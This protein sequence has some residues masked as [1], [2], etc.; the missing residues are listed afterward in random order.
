MMSFFQPEELHPFH[1]AFRGVMKFMNLENH[2]TLIS[3]ENLKLN[4][5]P[6]SLSHEILKAFPENISFFV[7]ERLISIGSLLYP[8]E[9]K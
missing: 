1:V 6:F 2:G 7:I 3:L 4:F 5:T 8:P 9:R